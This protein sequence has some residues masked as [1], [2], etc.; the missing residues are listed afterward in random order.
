MFMGRMSDPI[1]VLTGRLLFKPAVMVGLSL[2]MFF[3]GYRLLGPG[4]DALGYMRYRLAE[5]VCAQAAD[6]LPQ[7]EGLQT[8]AVLDLAG[9]SNGVVSA[10]LRS[11]IEAAG[12]YRL[13]DES[14]FRKLMQQLGKNSSPVVRLEDA[15]DAA[16]RIGVDAIVFGELPEFSATDNS[17]AMRL[18]IRMAERDSGKAVFAR[19]YR[20][21]MGGSWA[22]G[23][24]WRARLADSSSGRRIFLWVLFTLLLPL[25]TI[26]ILRKLTG[27]DSNLVNLGMLLGYTLLDMLFAFFLTGFWIPSLWTAAILLLALGSSAYYNYRIMSYVETM[28]R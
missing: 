4:K 9:D 28:R 14:F 12:V 22:A 2:V 21:T 13:L 3:E 11:K 26:P 15:V 18:E 24:Y 19:A 7:R 6:E 25:L 5:T 10:T 1:F 20:Q 27:M 17:A 16:R 8:L 23:A